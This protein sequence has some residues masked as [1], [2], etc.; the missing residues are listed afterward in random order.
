[1][2]SS[3]LAFFLQNSSFSRS[4]PSVRAQAM[5]CFSSITAMACAMSKIGPPLASTHS[6]DGNSGTS[7]SFRNTLCFAVAA[8]IAASISTKRA[9]AAPRSIPSSPTAVLM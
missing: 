5:P 8:L 9:W 2:K 6:A 3:R 1:M 7:N 4:T